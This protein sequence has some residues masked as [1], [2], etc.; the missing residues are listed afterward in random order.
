[1]RGSFLLNDGTPLTMSEL[2]GALA[3]ALALVVIAMFI[4]EIVMSLQRK[5]ALMGQVEETTVEEAETE[6]ETETEP[7]E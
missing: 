5:G 3:I 1:M 2:F 4:T 7:T 6:L